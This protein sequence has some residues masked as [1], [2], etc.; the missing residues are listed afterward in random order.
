[1]WINRQNKRAEMGL[2]KKVVSLALLK[3]VFILKIFKI[4][5]LHKVSLTNSGSLC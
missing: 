5:L 1:M 4:N 3:V 2:T